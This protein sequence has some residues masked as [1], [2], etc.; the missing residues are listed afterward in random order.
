[1]DSST[2]TL[3]LMIMHTQCLPNTMHTYI[4]LYIND[5]NYVHVFFDIFSPRLYQPLP[6]PFGRSRIW[7]LD[8]TASRFS[9][10]NLEKSWLEQ[11]FLGDMMALVSSHRSRSMCQCCHYA[12]YNH[13]PK[14]IKT[15]ELIAVKCCPDAWPKRRERDASPRPAKDFFEESISRGEALNTSG[16]MIKTIGDF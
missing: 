9:G 11:D 10:C 16:G 4:S 13:S 15:S 3:T 5:P 14:H 7:Q 12:I 2:Y 8:A 6:S 1:M